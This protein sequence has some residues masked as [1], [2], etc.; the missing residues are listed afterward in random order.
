MKIHPTTHRYRHIKPTNQ[1]W[2]CVSVSS[3]LWVSGGKQ[4]DLYRDKLALRPCFL[5]RAA[6]KKKKNRLILWGGFSL[7]H[8]RTSW[9]DWKLEPHLGVNGR[10][11]ALL[12]KTNR[13][14][15]SDQKQQG[16][17]VK[18][19][20]HCFLFQPFWLSCKNMWICTNT[21]GHMAVWFYMWRR[22]CFERGKCVQKIL[23]M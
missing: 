18:G 6:R 16:E 21:C 8:P 3:W 4:V 2:C 23:K 9:A 10:M 12:T 15:W 5:L 7:T 11:W 20:G 22:V 19:A 17:E 1:L 14:G 13:S